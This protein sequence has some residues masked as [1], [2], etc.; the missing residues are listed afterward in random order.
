MIP[1]R[2]TLKLATSLDGR[3]ALASG[4]SRWIT[5]PE[6]RAFGHALRAGHDAVLVGAGTMRADDPELTVRTDPLPA[7]QPLRV[8]ADP[9]LSITP[10]ARLL[11]TRAAG[12]VLIV[13]AVDASADR[14]EALRGAGATL[15]AATRDSTGGLDPQALL[16]AIAAAG[17]AS[18]LVEGGGRL[19]AS[20]LKAGRVDAIEWFRAPLLIGGDGVPGV[21]SLGLERLADAVRWRT[22]AIEPLGVD[23]RQ[24]LE[25]A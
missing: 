23:F 3:I 14:A 10:Q 1:L 4:E 5:G 6:A 22:T 17:A 19:A 16:G 25:R 24:R 2:V 11:A 12:P 20:L 21:G 9:S 15:A 8:V 7:R 18:I 13:H